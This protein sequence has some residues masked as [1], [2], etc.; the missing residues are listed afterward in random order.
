MMQSLVCNYKLQLQVVAAHSS[1]QQHVVAA[2]VTA[3]EQTSDSG[4]L[5]PTMSVTDLRQ[6]SLQFLRLGSQ[7][8]Q[9][10]TEASVSHRAPV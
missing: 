6:L 2:S 8:P 1:Q 4:G 7:D 3:L 5:G 10:L 9:T